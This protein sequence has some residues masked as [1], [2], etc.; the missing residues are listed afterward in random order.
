[1]RRG[2][3]RSGLAGVALAVLVAIL[4]GA[5]PPRVPADR[6]VPADDGTFRPTVLIRRGTMQG[7]GTVIASVEGET[8]VLTAAHVVRGPGELRV[9]LHRYNLGLEGISALG[10]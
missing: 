10:P 8:L 5:S 2:W 9:E 7:S 1:M 3:T 6:P 4:P